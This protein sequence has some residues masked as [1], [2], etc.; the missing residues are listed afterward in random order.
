[1]APS[2]GY[3]YIPSSKIKELL[4]DIANYLLHYQSLD[5]KK[6]III[7]YRFQLEVK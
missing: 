3:R 4:K 1:M 2:P 5:L 7:S 6:H